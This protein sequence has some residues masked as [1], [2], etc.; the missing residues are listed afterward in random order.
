MGGALVVGSH[1]L[2]R[3]FADAGHDV[4]HLVTPVTPFHAFLIGKPA[5]RHRLAAAL[6]PAGTTYPSVRQLAPVSLVP[7]SLARFAPGSGDAVVAATIPPLRR[8][9]RRLGY[10][11]VDVLLLDDPWLHGLLGL[12]EAAVRIYRPTDLYHLVTGQRS[13]ALERCI[14]SAVDGLVAT[15]A[16][17]RDDVLLRADGVLPAIV[18]E[19]G[20]DVA[21][22]SAPRAEP[23]AYAD[24]SPPRVVYTGA[25]DDRFDWEALIRAAERRSRACFVLIGPVTRK[26]PRPAPSNV[27]LLGPRPYEVLPAY[28]QHADVGLIPLGEHPSNRGRSPMKLYEYLA[29]GLPV[30][31][32][33]TPE[34][35]R[36]ATPHVHLYESGEDLAGTLERLLKAPPD[37]EACRAA[38]SGHDWKDVARRILD[39]AEGLA[40]SG[41]AR[42]TTEG[43]RSARRD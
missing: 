26:P 25:L 18:V 24:L 29:A 15:S 41:T 31:A 37:P 43:G 20:V 36:R 34:L 30:A 40:P 33:A 13:A 28:L 6:G 4:L 12:V 16:P 19:N 21:H 39:F 2:A 9:L 27:H 7:G 11:R 35:E 22:M 32:R 23:A 38:A 42:P 17:V 1:H 8:R 3:T 14:L 5:V 10:E